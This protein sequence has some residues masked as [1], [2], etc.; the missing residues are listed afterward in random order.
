MKELLFLLENSIFLCAVKV[1][2]N[3]RKNLHDQ[4]CEGPGSIPGLTSQTVL[5]ACL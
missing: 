1:T 2:E 3:Y 5:H 4:P